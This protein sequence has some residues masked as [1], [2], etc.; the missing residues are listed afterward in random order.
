MIKDKS[1]NYIKI[2]KNIMILYTEKIL[3]KKNDEIVFMI[4]LFDNML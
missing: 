2:K 1:E 4:T 3:M